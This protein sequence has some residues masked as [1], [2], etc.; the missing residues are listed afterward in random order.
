MQVVLCSVSVFRL[1]ARAVLGRPSRWRCWTQVQIITP[2]SSGKLLLL[3]HRDGGWK[4]KR[5][6]R[7]EAGLL[8]WTDATG[9]TCIRCPA[10]ATIWQQTEWVVQLGQ[11]QPETR[12]SYKSK[13]RTNKEIFQSNVSSL[14]SS[15]PEK[16]SKW[17]LRHKMAK[18]NSPVFCVSDSSICSLR[19]SSSSE[20][21]PNKSSPETRMLSQRKG[22]AVTFSQSGDQLLSL[23]GGPRWGS[24]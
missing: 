4:R 14:K 6:I 15:R 21:L 2:I 13:Q 11:G 24:R 5:K 10:I 7:L 8:Q 3:L 22:R 17:S 23:G 16:Q 12:V 9:F 1:V 19:S 18:E 20:Q